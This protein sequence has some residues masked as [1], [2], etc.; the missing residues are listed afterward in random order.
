MI[1]IKYD[2]PILKISTEKKRK[3]SYIY[4]G[5]EDIVISNKSKK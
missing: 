1:G 3:Q 4:F 5:K 2:V